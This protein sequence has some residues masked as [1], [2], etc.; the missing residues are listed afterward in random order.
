MTLKTTLQ[1]TWHFI[2]HSDSGWSWLANIL[3]AFL[4]IRFIVYPLL[5]LVFGTGYPIVA[6]VSESMEH[7]LHDQGLCGATFTEYKESFSNYWRVCGSWYEQRNISLE[8][9]RKFPFPNGFNKGDIILLFGSKPEKLEIGKVIIFQ[10]DK[11]QPII[12]RV[13]KKWQENGTYYF[14]TKGDHNSDSLSGPMGER[15]INEK[16]IVGKGVLRIPYLGWIKIIFVQAV[17]PLGWTITR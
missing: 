3:I 14:Q 16:R 12:H 10:G 11:P 6:V 8:Q 7:G 13:V 15:S 9:F 5:G 2:W 4:L 1:K 17:A